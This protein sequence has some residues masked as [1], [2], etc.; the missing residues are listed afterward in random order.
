MIFFIKIFLILHFIHV[1]NY[2]NHFLLI[3]LKLEKKLK[4]RPI[5]RFFRAQFAELGTGL[6][7]NQ[8][9]FQKGLT[10]QFMV[11]KEPSARNSY[12]RQNSGLKM[13]FSRRF[14]D[15]FDFFRFIIFFLRDYKAYRNG[16]Y[17]VGISI[18][19]AF[20]KY[21]FGGNLRHF[22]FFRKNPPWTTPTP[23]NRKKTLYSRLSSPNTANKT[24]K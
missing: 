21:F 13:C 9:R 1:T 19:W 17:L 7:L 15:F 20:R 3:C 24:K 16:P 22:I 23:Q 2:S 5:F 8:R 14:F 11:V 18:K 10:L 6:E 12:F 4:K